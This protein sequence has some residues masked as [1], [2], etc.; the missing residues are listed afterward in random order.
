MAVARPLEAQERADLLGPQRD[1]LVSELRKRIP[2]ARRLSDADRELV[3]DEAMSYVVVDHDD[4][5][6]VSADDVH[7]CSGARANCGF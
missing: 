2:H 6:L 1:A 7:A 5:P 3:V 4:P